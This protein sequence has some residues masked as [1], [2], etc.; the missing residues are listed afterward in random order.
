MPALSPVKGRQ[1]EESLYE[2]SWETFT[3]GNG[4]ARYGPGRVTTL[5]LPVLP[6]NVCL[7]AFS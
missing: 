4:K 7:S 1:Q 3:E 6:S 2:D 5:V